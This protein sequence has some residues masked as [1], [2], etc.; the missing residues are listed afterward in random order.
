MYTN[1]EIKE[2]EHVADTASFPQDLRGLFKHDI[3]VK[4]TPTTGNRILDMSKA[5]EK[6]TVEETNEYKRVVSL[7][8]SQD[9]INR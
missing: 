9:A 1:K 8:V 3:V 7:A 5:V 6:M 2:V 4:L